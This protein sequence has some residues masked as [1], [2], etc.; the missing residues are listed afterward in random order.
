MLLIK[1]YLLFFDYVDLEYG[2]E[3]DI[4]VVGGIIL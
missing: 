1:V 3:G 4:Y 2:G